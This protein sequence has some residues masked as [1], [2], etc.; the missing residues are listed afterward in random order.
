MDSRGSAI[1]QSKPSWSMRASCLCEYRALLLTQSGENTFSSKITRMGSLKKHLLNKG[2]LSAPI[3]QAM[4]QASDPSRWLHLLGSYR[5]LVV[6]YASLAGAGHS[7][8]ALCESVPF[9]DQITL[10][11]IKL[12]IPSDPDKIVARRVS[13]AHVEDPEQNY[14]RFLNALKVPSLALDGLRYAHSALGHLAT[15]AQ[16][17]AAISPV[18]PEMPVLTEKDILDLTIV[19]E[20]DSTQVE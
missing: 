18:K 4:N 2:D 5:D 19:D 8:Y 7:L 6:H 12:P 20:S 9:Q 13:G 14:A 3:D 10:P 1:W 16:A 11:S 15:L 17:L